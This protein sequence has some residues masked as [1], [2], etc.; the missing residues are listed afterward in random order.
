M[1]I[2]TSSRHE[3]GFTR[4]FC[5]ILGAAHGLSGILQMLL[6]VPDFL[7]TDS[8][9]EAV[10]RAAV[11][12]MLTLQQPNGNIAPALDE[13]FG[14]YKRPASEELVHWCHGGPGMLTKRNKNVLVS[15]LSVSE[16][17]AAVSD[18]TVLLVAI[19]VVVVVCRP[20]PPNKYA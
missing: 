11:D 2:D 17:A 6:S 7:S 16:S 15:F 5:R 10:V 1:S 3:D 4:Y 18:T 14:G 19:I 13:V 12:F 9:V 20:P 8:D